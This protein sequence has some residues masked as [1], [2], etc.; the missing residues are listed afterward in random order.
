[1]DNQCTQAN[2]ATSNPAKFVNAPG[3][4]AI[5]APGVELDVVEEPVVVATGV[6]VVLL[7]LELVSVSDDASSCAESKYLSVWDDGLPVKLARC[8]SS[9][10]CPPWRYEGAVDLFTILAAAAKASMVLPKVGA[11]HAPTM[12]P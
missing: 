8:S 9:S 3:I 5:A 1:M 6:A 2:A 4:T 12:P 10:S 7:V 11:F